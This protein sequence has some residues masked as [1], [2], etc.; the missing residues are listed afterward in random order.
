MRSEIRQTEKTEGAALSVKVIKENKK[1]APLPIYPS[2]LVALGLLVFAK[3]SSDVMM[4]RAGYVDALI[5]DWILSYVS[6]QL[7]PVMIAVTFLGNAKVV[8]LIF[9]SVIGMLIFAAKRQWEAIV[10]TVSVLG[11]WGLNEGLKV[12][13]NR[14]RPAFQQL[15]EVDGYSF[16]SGH[17]MV[18]WYFYGFLGY[19]WY[20]YL[21][22]RGKP[23]W[24]VPVVTGTVILFIGLSRIYLGVHYASDVLAGYII[25]AIWLAVCL[26]FFHKRPAKSRYS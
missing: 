5:G 23:Y 21:K 3:L 20:T 12:L 13:F 17:A 8:A 14:D 7:T 1:S 9:L 2:I 22:N 10:L 4:G 25:G 11:G 15:V 18:A 16:P 19:M 26:F 24:Y 6:E